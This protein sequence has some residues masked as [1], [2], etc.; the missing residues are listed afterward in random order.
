M[1]TASI[2]GET[3][4]EA[5]VDGVLVVDRTGAVT[6][7]N[8]AAE[9]LL[10]YPVGTLIGRNLDDL[11]P[12]FEHSGPGATAAGTRP[13]AS[14]RRQTAVRAD[15]TELTVTVSTSPW[16]GDGALAVLRDAT[17]ARD[18]AD[19]LV[20]EQRLLR[21]VA[22]VSAVL[23][24]SA[25]DSDAVLDAAARI[26]ADSIGDACVIALLDE[27]SGR[28]RPA[29]FHHR[30]TEG[31]Q[32]M[33]QALAGNGV[34]LGE[35]PVGE[36]A[37]SGI[38]MVATGLPDD[39]VRARLAPEHRAFLD[40]HPLSAVAI[41]PLVASDQIIGALAL[42]GAHEY[43]A[44]ERVLVKDLADRVALAADR[45]RLYDREQEALR[46]AE[47]AHQRLKAVADS[48]PA[49]IAYWD[50]HLIN[51]FANHTY[52]DYFGL[53]PEEIR[54]RHIR[55]VL[56][57]ETLENNLPYV[58]RALAGEHVTFDRAVRDTAGKLHHTQAD[59]APVV[60]DGEV[61]GF[62][63]LAVDV[64]DRV[65]A[66]ESLKASEERYRTIADRYRMLAEN[67]SDVV[68]RL[69]LDLV[70]QWV[71]PSVTDV[72][73]Y[74]ADEVVGR[75]VLDGLPS[76]VGPGMLAA[77]RAN[78]DKPNSYE[79]RFRA[80]DGRWRWLSVN[81]R[82]VR[83]HHGVV[84]GR[85]GSCHDIDAQMAD[86][87]ALARSEKLFRLA[88]ESA[89]SGMAVVDLDRRFL[90]VNPTLCR[91]IG[92][93]AGWLLSRRVPNV[94]DPADDRR[95]VRRRVSLLAGH[96][97]APADE[98]RLMAADG[99]TVWAQHQIG[100]LRDDDGTPLSFVSQ[101]IDI[102]EARESRQSLQF[103]A[104]H[105][106]LTGLFNRSEVLA[107]MRRVLAHPVRH[108]SRSAV[109][110]VDVDDLKPLNDR[111]GH[112]AGDEMLVA[113]A[114]RLR[115]S[116]REHDVVARLGGDEFV[117]FLTGLRTDD[118][119]ADLA[120]KILQATREPVDIEGTPVVA[121][122]SIGI[123]ATAPGEDADDAI[124]RAD[125]ALYRAK[126]HGGDTASV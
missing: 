57:A 112:A 84:V 94:I 79:A 80:A 27:D 89:P 114:E 43:T 82:P 4:L 98:I 3:V 36:V 51:R 111:L 45:A 78:P 91:M 81:T 75:S 119:A 46:N 87:Q 105:D 15:G 123:A 33:A 12:L 59:Y 62:A 5:L 10:G 50:C 69:D 49:M 34:E 14:A 124:R 72:L 24:R 115:R 126:A 104:S 77:V 8:H 120:D 53:T 65:I 121:T 100:L 61:A 23:A 29:A 11:L 17:P 125:A 110:F 20:T 19:R 22:D 28:L 74:E 71:S 2:T 26:L 85:I 18:L 73:G 37:R 63:V 52:G 16:Q 101:F 30:L 41:M 47:E 83:D 96:G 13:Q 35:G 117:V 106:Q 86:R 70:V 93:D 21:I 40:E 67:A 108:G 42:S 122:V 113:V 44:D 66:T 32:V 107:R 102:T 118:D 109:L 99:R 31:E 38:P 60:I 92:R 76:Q 25:P 54:G 1:D 7:A 6:Y 56:D 9:R 55:D 97:P 90:Q 68:F 64:T 116:V 39:E 103:V 48:T 88:L 95:D 58:E